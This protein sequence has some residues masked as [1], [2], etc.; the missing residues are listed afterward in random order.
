[1]NMPSIC[2]HIC[3]E[4]KHVDVSVKK[5]PE[6]ISRLVIHSNANEMCKPGTAVFLPYCNSGGVDSSGGGGGRGGAVGA[7][8]R[9]PSINQPVSLPSDGSLAAALSRYQPARET[10]QPR[11]SAPRCTALHSGE[12]CTCVRAARSGR[13][14]P[15]A[16]PQANCRHTRT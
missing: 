9:A 7:A 1:M 4:L 2:L 3:V 8:G 6:I 11:G 5:L 12:R 13:E 14:A 15:P 10:R 16:G